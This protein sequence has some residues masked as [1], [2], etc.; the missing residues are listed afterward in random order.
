MNKQIKTVL[1]ASLISMFFFSCSNNAHHEDHKQLGTPVVKLNNGAAWTAN[2]ETTAGINKM[3]LIIEKSEKKNESSCKDLGVSLNQ[4]FNQILKK[5]SMKGEAHEQLHHYLMPIIPV[6][7]KIEQGQSDDCKT[8]KDE[9]KEY[10]AQYDN[11][12]RS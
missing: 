3:I 5:C 9:L 6:I 7:D 1:A 11:Y 4:E 8:A 2:A 12:F 10:L